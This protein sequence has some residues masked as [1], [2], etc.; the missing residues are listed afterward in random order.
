MSLET[1]MTLEINKILAEELLTQE[2]PYATVEEKAAIMNM[3]FGDKGTITLGMLHFCI[4]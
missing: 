1:E 2:H 4:L 3:I